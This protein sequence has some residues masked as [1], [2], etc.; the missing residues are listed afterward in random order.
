MAKTE[1]KVLENKLR[2]I[3][4]RRGLRLEKS[5]RRDPNAI[6]YGGYMLVDAYS[7]TVVAGA[8]HHAYDCTLA[9]I[10]TQLDHGLKGKFPNRDTQ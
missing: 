3:A 6:D 4:A 10:Q 8:T 9:E 2:R 1:D 5:R 7:N